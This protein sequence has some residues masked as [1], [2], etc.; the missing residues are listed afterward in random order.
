[1]VNANTHIFLPTA[2]A[3]NTANVIKT[4]AGCAVSF[5]LRCNG[6]SI[7]LK[8]TLTYFA[9]HS[10][11]KRISTQ[12]VRQKRHCVTQRVNFSCFQFLCHFCH[13]LF[14]LLSLDLSNA[15]CQLTVAKR[16]LTIG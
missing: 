5:Y 8:G 16:E 4:K 13:F 6:K 15:K 14:A 11:R 7:A 2:T 10:S 9:S 12:C 3:I 1:M